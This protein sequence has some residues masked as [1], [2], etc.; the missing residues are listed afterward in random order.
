M[1]GTLVAFLTA[2]IC[3]YT[4]MACY[5]THKLTIWVIYQEAMRR[6]FMTWDAEN[7]YMWKVW[8]NDSDVVYDNSVEEYVPRPEIP[9]GEEMRI[10]Q[11]EQ[12]IDNE[13]PGE[14][15]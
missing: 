12:T 4:V 3:V 15:A 8:V 6:G 5:F 11:F 13:E 10:I 2:A 14:H 9:H 1:Q 7:G